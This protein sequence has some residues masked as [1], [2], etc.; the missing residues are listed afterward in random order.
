V[1]YRSI[2]SSSYRPRATIGL[3]YFFGFFWLFCFVL[4]AP[5]LWQ[6]YQDVSA[7]AAKW[8]AAQQSV[9]AAFRPRLWLAVGL[10]AGITVV[11]GR[12]RLLPGT[13]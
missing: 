3:F 12:F 11:G 10:A 5:T 13:R 8:D 1:A 4:I 9:Q 2:R 7:D 6:A